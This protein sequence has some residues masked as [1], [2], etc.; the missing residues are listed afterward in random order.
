M[1]TTIVY[2]LSRIVEGIGLA[3]F[4]VAIA[5]IV[6]IVVIVVVVLMLAP[7]QPSDFFLLFFY[8]LVEITAS[9][10][11]FRFCIVVV[12]RAVGFGVFIWAQK[13]FTVFARFRDEEVNRSEWK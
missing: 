2:W 4:L 6:V 12:I 10:T 7:P 1:T 11:L 13:S 8:L 5:V 9:F 3:I